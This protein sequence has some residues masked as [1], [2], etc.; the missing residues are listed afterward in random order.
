MRERGSATD[1]V[2]V[3]VGV[4][5]AAAAVF[6]A[7]RIGVYY[8]AIRSGDVSKL[9][10]FSSSLSFDPEA[11]ETA[12]A[13]AERSLLETDDDPSFGA[14][15]AQLVIVEFADYECPFCQQASGI[16][17][18]VASRYADRVR[19]IVRDFPVNELHPNALLAAEALGC[20]EEQGVYWSMHDRAFANGAPLDRSTLER[21]AEQSGA[22]PE[23]F[24]ACMA[25]HRRL[26]EVQDDIAAADAAGVR[27]TPTFFFNG[28][29]VEGTIPEDMFEALVKGFL[30][31]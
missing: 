30:G 22:D 19:V 17:R 4:V 8:F 26:E 23:E 15:D 27:G 6:M 2:V 31:E 3:V 10:Q 12:S 13:N 28:Q 14:A 7:W 1:K 9:P 16:V 24:K 20:A 18:P 5:I 29:R 25:S 21:L 11:A